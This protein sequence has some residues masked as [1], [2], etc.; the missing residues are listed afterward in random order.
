MSESEKVEIYDVTPRDGAQGAGINFIL[1]D[2]IKII[3][4]DD[5]RGI[6]GVEAGFPGSNNDHNAV[7]EAL[8]NEK[9]EFVSYAAFGMT[10]RKGKSVEHDEGLQ[11]LLDSCAPW[12][13]IV[14]K[15]SR[16]HIEQ[17]LKTTT[18]TNRAMIEESLEYLRKSG[19]FSRVLYDAEHFF[20][21]F[22]DDPTL[23]LSTLE[24][25]VKGGAD[26]LVLCDT[27]GGSFPEEIT[28]AVT[29]VR[30]AFGH[31]LLGIH[32][33]N[34]GDMATANTLAAVEAGARHV[35]GTWNGYGER[36]GNADLFS[37]IPNL[38]R[39][40][41]EV[42][43]TSNFTAFSREIDE[44]A[45]QPRFHR[46][47]F[48]GK[49]AFAHKGGMHVAALNRHRRAYEF[50]DPNTVGNESSIVGSKLSGIGNVVNIVTHAQAIDEET[51]ERIL[52][53]KSLQNKILR[54][55]EDHDS[56]G[57]AVEAAPA[58]L[59]L[60]ALRAIDAFKPKI[61]EVK[62]PTVH[63][64]LGGLTEAT[65]KVLINGCEE[66]Q[67]I[68]AEGDGQIDALSKALLKAMRSQYPKL[69]EFR[70]TDYEVHKLP[71]P[72]GTG[73]R[74]Q[75]V[76]EFSDGEKSWSTSCISEDQT[77]AAWICVKDAIEY[78]LLSNGHHD[79]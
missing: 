72:G 70:L 15:S 47:S 69:A 58:T 20:D 14:G 75:V 35:Q 79:E 76:A 4:S 63:D 30:K 66:P 31:I 42:P 45:R 13:T 9:L 28:R 68:V 59:E 77:L 62:N 29:E 44:M 52:N 33:H 16:M 41:Y 37:V 5:E 10:R 73:S 53:D 36:A 49:Y 65:I 32:V 39:R 3:K 17:V 22:A 46:R 56:N 8:R 6:H 23:A 25:A 78:M 40:G 26:T 50:I 21:G 27:N 60:L 61:T 64:E 54:A 7:F 18:D 51:R 38:K 19:K 71:G 55:M 24:A 48:V 2:T 12:V 74:V 1:D 11:T 34:D 43:D 57:A 67:H